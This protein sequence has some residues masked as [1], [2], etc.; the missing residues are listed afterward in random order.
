MV[1]ELVD[2]HYFA[3]ICNQSPP[4]WTYKTWEAIPSETAWF[5]ISIEFRWDFGRERVLSWSSLMLMFLS[6]S[7]QLLYRPQSCLF[8]STFIFWQDFLKDW[9][10]QEGKA[11]KRNDSTHRG[12]TWSG[13]QNQQ[14]LWVDIVLIDLGPCDRPPTQPVPQNAS[15]SSDPKCLPWIVWYVMSYYILTWRSYISNCIV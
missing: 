15:Y 9:L 1:M 13:K 4:F 7:I 12:E 14:V 10:L 8:L 11:A 2:C 6:D 3:I 5:S